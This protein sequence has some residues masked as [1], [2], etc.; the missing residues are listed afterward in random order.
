MNRWCLEELVR[1]DPRNFVILLQKI[2]KKTEEVA[3]SEGH[4]D[5]SR[6]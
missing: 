5:S 4:V 2:L 6:L 1:R 3:V